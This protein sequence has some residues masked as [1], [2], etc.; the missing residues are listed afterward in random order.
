MLP[1]VRVCTSD[2]FSFYLVCIN[3]RNMV[4][5]IIVCALAI[6]YAP[7]KWSIIFH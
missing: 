3:H 5:I 6:F 4:K 1:L 2:H 7:S